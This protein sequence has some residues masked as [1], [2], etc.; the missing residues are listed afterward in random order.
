[1]SIKAGANTAS[2]LKLEPAGLSI[3]VPLFKNYLLFSP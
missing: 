1:M 3:E 2:G